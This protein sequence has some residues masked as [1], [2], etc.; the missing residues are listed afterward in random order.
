MSGSRRRRG[1]I[2][3]ADL[4]D[5][6][7]NDTFLYLR[8]QWGSER[9]D[10]YRNLLDS[11]RLD[12]TAIIELGKSRR[13][14]D[15]LN[16]AMEDGRFK[17]REMED[18][19]AMFD[20]VREGFMQIERRGRGGD[21]G[22]RRG[23]RDER[24]E[25][26]DRYERGSRSRRGGGERDRYGRRGER[27]D[28]YERSDRRRDRGGGESLTGSEVWKEL[29]RHKEDFVP[30][31][32]FTDFV[33]KDLN[34]QLRDIDLDVLKRLMRVRSRNPEISREDFFGL[35]PKNA[36]FE[37][38]I[39]E[40]IREHTGARRGSRNDRRDRV[41]PITAAHLKKNKEL[42][43]LS[44]P[45]FLDYLLWESKDLKYAV[46][47]LRRDHDL[48]VRELIDLKREDLVDRYG[49]QK[50][51]AGLSRARALREARGSK[52]R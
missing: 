2:S 42:T 3:E 23:Y 50:D 40:A 22:E 49:L 52:R 20:E 4:R 16:R 38:T 15:R 21:R 12:G 24:D 32:V 35:F 6:T 39:F 45:E 28:Y 46:A 51:E 48:R 44:M 41:A 25:D 43:K 31:D 36:A 1:R 9:A 19:L 18:L 13:A 17:R 8:D 27:D 30:F 33:K 11:E 7:E 47:L 14:G 29:D 34:L 37:D 26:S 5:W 10:L